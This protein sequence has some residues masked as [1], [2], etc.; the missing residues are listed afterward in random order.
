MPS[1][2]KK[3]ACENPLCRWQEVWKTM[4]PQAMNATYRR[5]S[6]ESTRTSMPSSPGTNTPPRGGLLQP[7]KQDMGHPDTGWPINAQ[8]EMAGQQSSSEPPRQF[9]MPSTFWN[10]C[11]VLQSQP[12]AGLT[13]NIP[14]NI[15]CGQRGCFSNH[16]NRK[17]T[18]AESFLKFTGLQK[19]SRGISDI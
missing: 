11:F 9:H 3:W 12:L 14:S 19:P 8:K 10:R 13:I 5:M 7:V 17:E 2:D 6:V 4:T 18:Q 1:L 16:A 15:M